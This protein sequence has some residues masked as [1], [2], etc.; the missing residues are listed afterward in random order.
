MTHA[1]VAEEK[2]YRG[3]SRGGKE[4]RRK[5]EGVTR[6]ERRE[7]REDGHE[8]EEKEVARRKWK[9]TRRKRRENYKV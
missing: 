7:G 3:S 9:V 8:K 2:V 1:E 6:N 4:G 5:R